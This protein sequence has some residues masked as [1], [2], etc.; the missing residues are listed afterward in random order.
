MSEPKPDLQIFHW[1]FPLRVRR[2]LCTVL[3]QGGPLL[4]LLENS[5]LEWYLG[6]V[7]L[8]PPPTA[9][10]CFSRIPSE[11]VL[12]SDLVVFPQTATEPVQGSVLNFSLWF[13]SLVGSEVAPHVFWSGVSCT[14]LKKGGASDCWRPPPLP[15]VVSP[16]LALG[17]IWILPLEIFTGFIPLLG[18]RV[19][20]RSLKSAKRHPLGLSSAFKIVLTMLNLAIWE[21]K[22]MLNFK[23]WSTR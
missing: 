13:S 12:V 14:G 8:P 18:P 17:L 1:S 4:L 10:G 22:K 11:P 15:R 6:L 3:N 2:L 20:L 21:I 5:K 9:K 23:L 19:A 7:P 16:Y